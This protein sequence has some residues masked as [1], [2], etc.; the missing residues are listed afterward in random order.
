MLL[1][2]LAKLGDLPNTVFTTAHSGIQI[3]PVNYYEGDI[4]RQ[5]RQMVKIEYGEG[6]AADVK[7]FGAEQT[8]CMAQVAKPSLMD[9]VGDVVVR[10]FPYDPND[11]YFETDSIE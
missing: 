9:Y 3:A 2:F 8:Q 4:T 7:T 6:K 11:P 1:I 10:K 5:T